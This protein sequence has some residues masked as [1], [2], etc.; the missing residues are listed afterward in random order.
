MHELGSAR[1][2]HK[3]RPD[4]AVAP[5]LLA[6]AGVTVIWYP[7]PPPPYQITSKMVPTGYHFTGDLVPGV[8]IYNYI[9]QI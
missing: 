7:P 4:H 9:Y 2:G 3:G 8:Y 1:A 5:A 6:L